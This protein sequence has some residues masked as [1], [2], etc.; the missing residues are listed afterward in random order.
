MVYQGHL[1]ER[2]TSLTHILDTAS[3]MLLLYYL[4]LHVEVLEIPREGIFLPLL[5]LQLPH[6][7]LHPHRIFGP[8]PAS[9]SLAIL[10]WNFYGL[11]S[12]MTIPRLKELIKQHDPDILFLSETKN[13]DD[14]VIKESTPLKLDKHFIFTPL[15][16]GAR[17]LALYR[18]A[19]IDIQILSASQN[20]ID[21]Q[22]SFKNTSFHGT[23]VYRAPDIPNRQGVWDQL[24]T[25][26]L[27]R[28]SPWF[29][30]GDFNKRV[31]NAENSGGTVRP[32]S[33]SA[34][35]DLS[36]Q[37]ATY[38]TSNTRV[39]SCL[40]GD[41]DTLILF[42]VVLIE[43]WATLLGQISSLNPAPTISN[44]KLLITCPLSP[45]WKS[46][47]KKQSGF[48]ATIDACAII[49]MLQHWSTRRGSLRRMLCR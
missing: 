21:I 23:F 39:I 9:A 43:R 45:F 32:E 30:T 27:T 1:P 28:D 46:G 37:H 4:C 36:S 10:S 14:F 49:Q 16:L 44:L 40:G 13:P 8:L 7:D 6:I 20:F 19:D 48:S 15:S 38:L 35:S 42:T 2:G 22:I 47:K 33:S 24:T 26:S 17:G 31:G 3:L 29:L 34:H 18:K 5:L 11:D 25:I 41:K 12:P